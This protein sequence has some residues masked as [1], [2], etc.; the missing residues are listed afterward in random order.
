MEM[1]DKL[2][3]AAALAAVR[4]VI[5]N[6]PGVSRTHPLTTSA[7]KLNANLNEYNNFLVNHVVL[8]KEKLHEL[9]FQVGG[10]ATRPLLEDHPNYVFPAERVKEAIEQVCS[11]FGISKE[12]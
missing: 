7:E 12:Q 6:G 5:E 2:E 3:T 4:A 9:V 10:A 1:L 11:E 8:T